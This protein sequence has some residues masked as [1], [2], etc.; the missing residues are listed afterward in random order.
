MFH[1]VGYS[2]I[3]ALCGLINRLIC[4]T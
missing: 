1:K 3:D 2:L 4:H